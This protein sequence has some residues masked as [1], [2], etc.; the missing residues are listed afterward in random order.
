V[1]RELARRGHRVVG[2][3]LDASMVSQARQAAP[4]ATWIEADLL[5]VG[6]ADV[7]A[8]VDAVVLAGNVVVY[9]TGGT[10]A[11]VVAHLAGWL[12][13][14]GLL[15]AGFATDRHVPVAGYRRW[16]AS[17]GLTQ[18]SAQAG[19]DGAAAAPE[20]DAAADRAYAVLVHRR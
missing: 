9:L 1:A 10:E 7:G 15:V 5:D 20:T 16:C 14:G 13:P 18:V 2:V 6:A 11:A 17:A 3:D 4:S 19:W 8:P 12:R